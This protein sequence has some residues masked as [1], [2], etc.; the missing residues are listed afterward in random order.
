MRK[1]PF[2]PARRVL[3]GAVQ[4]QSARRDRRGRRPRRRAD[5]GDR[6]LDQSERDHVP[7]AAEGC[8]PPTIMSAS[9]RRARAAIRRTSDTGFLSC[10]ARARRP[11]QGETVVQE[12][13]AGLV[14]MK[15]DGARLAVRGAAAAARPARSSSRVCEAASR[16]AAALQS[17]AIKAA[18]WVDNGPGWV[19]V[20]L[21]SR[22]EVLELKRDSA[23]LP[24][25]SLGV[26]AP[27][28]GVATAAR[29]S[30]R[31]APSCLAAAEDP[32]TGSLERES[33]AMADRRRPREAALCRRAGHRARPR[34]PGPCGAGGRCDLDRRRCRRLRR[35]HDPPP[36][37]KS[38]EMRDTSR[39]RRAEKSWRA[40]PA[41]SARSKP[42]QTRDHHE[43]DRAQ[44]LREVIA[45]HVHE[46]RKERAEEDHHLGVRQQHQEPL[47]EEAAARRRRRR[48][49]PMP[50]TG[51]RISLMPSQTR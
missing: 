36:I 46:L 9:S 18:Q 41:S 19:A 5:A 47:Q 30:S 31:S 24:D 37:M 49:A 16:I 40:R 34:R 43:G 22:R 35:R 38:P 2:F 28:A 23:G 6:Q 15:R 25:Q 50:S 13:G 29:R 10:V 7:V 51:E 12:C 3:R 20:L 48:V 11:A 42:H 33:R 27:W 39:V 8:R 1:L 21:G 4:G 26:V 14:R 44:R 32:V 17:R 45:A